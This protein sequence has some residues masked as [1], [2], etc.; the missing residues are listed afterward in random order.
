MGMGYDEFMP[1][2]ASTI[3]GQDSSSKEGD[4]GWTN[5]EF[6]SG[7]ADWPGLFIQAGA[8]RSGAGYEGECLA[9]L[10]A[11]ARWL[12]EHSQGQVHIV[13][14]IWIEPANKKVLVEKWISDSQPTSSRFNVFRAAEISIYQSTMPSVITGTPLVLEFDKMFCRYANR[15]Q[16]KDIEFDERELN[17]WAKSLFVGL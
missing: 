17:E 11:D 15:P 10:Q 9:R 14:L 4:S 6:R 3:I 1:I 2:G 16:E 8:S 13:L 12:L 7:A 5:L